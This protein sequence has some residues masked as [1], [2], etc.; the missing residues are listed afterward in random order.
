MCACLILKYSKILALSANLN[1]YSND[2]V[3]FCTLILFRA[4]EWNVNKWAWEGMLKVVSRGEE[5]II[6]LEDKNSGFFIGKL[7]FAGK[8]CESTSLWTYSF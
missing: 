4:D 8:Q 2:R 6:K 3:L 1:L 7:F 5:C